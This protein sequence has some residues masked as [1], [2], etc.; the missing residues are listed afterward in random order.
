M[1][2]QNEVKIIISADGSKAIAVSKEVADA[3]KTLGTQTIAG[4]EAQKAQI[5]AAYQTISTSGQA[6]AEE[7]KHAEDAKITAISN[8]NEQLV[9]KSQG[10]VGQIK[11][12]WLGLAAGI[13]TAMMAI[14]KGTE[15]FEMGRE[16]APDRNGFQGR[17]LVG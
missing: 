11:E 4:V 14:N 5:T 13:G 6:S 15:F 17:R 3:Y 9:N 10:W 7:I 12:H 2:E 8:L 1:G 16:G